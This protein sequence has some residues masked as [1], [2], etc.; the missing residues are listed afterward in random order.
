MRRS[1]LVLLATMGL[2][3]ACGGGGDGTGTLAVSITD[4]PFPSG[5]DCLAFANVTVTSVAAKVTDLADS[6]PKGWV[7]VPL[8]DAPVTVNLLDLR[9][10][11]SSALGSVDL[12]TGTYKEIRL[13]LG[14]AVLEFADGS[15]Q[16]FKVPS[17]SSSG[18]KIKIEPDLV[19]VAGE[20]SELLLDLDLA[21]S[22]KAGGAG[23]DPTCD[24]LK[25]GEAKVKFSPVVRAVNLDLTGALAGTVKD[26]AGDAVAEA[27]ITVYAKGTDVA[28]NPEPA[29][30]T[31]SVG[32]GLA[33]TAAGAWAVRLE[34][35]EYDVY[36]RAPGGDDR[37]LAIEGASVQAGAITDGQ[38]IVLP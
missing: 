23:G 15:Q 36:V 38:E 17:G 6:D 31:S 21:R 7:E 4:A 13:V 11:L 1:V 30:T 35:G 24:E 18:L 37:V 22:F 12:A 26:A 16:S 3:V 29:A 25:K 34:A 32:A 28:G 8:G 10:G 5:A 9:A 19:I 14:D 2:V 20:T 33:N 27:E